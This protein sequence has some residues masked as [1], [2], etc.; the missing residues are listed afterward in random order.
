MVQMTMDVS[1]ELA[2]TFKSIGP[3][4]PA[5][6]ELSL[7]GFKSLAAAPASEVVQFLSRNPSYE[8]VLDFHISESSQSRLRRLLALNEAGLLSQSEG[9]ELD[10]LQRLEHAIIML[11]A[12]IAAHV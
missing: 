4:L 12:R 5:I 10:E 8:E 3:W 9:N 6:I 11:K 2:D 7:L 1:D